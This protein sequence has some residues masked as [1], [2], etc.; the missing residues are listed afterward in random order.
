[1][2]NFIHHGKS[3]TH[4]PVAVVASG[5][6]AKIGS[7][8]GIAVSNVAAGAPGVFAVEG[9]HRLP[10]LVGD[11]VGQGDTVR[12]DHLQ[13]VITTATVGAGNASIAAAGFAVTA[14]AAAETVIDI[15]INA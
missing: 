15:K 3:I 6:V 12:W 13:G 4:T 5:G 14:A 2:K 9:V 1:M 10:K 7:R 11:P 8:I